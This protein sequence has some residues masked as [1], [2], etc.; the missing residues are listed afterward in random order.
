MVSYLNDLEHASEY[1]DLC[2]DLDYLLNYSL[3]LKKFIENNAADASEV[4]IQFKRGVGD[5]NKKIIDL[6]KNANG[7]TM[8]TKC[9]KDELPALL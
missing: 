8:K 1:E 9:K 6:M 4:F 2:Q 5:R 7:I 3:K